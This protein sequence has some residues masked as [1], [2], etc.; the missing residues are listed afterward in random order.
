[1][2]KNGCCMNCLKAGHM[3]NKCRAP[4]SCRKCRKTHHTLL[5]I[6]S[7]EPREE[8]ASETINNVTHV[9]QLKRNKQVL[10]MTCRAKIFGPDGNFTQARVF[11]DP[12]AACSFITEELAQ[13]LRLP[14]RKSNTVIAGIAGVNAT[15]TRGAVSFTLG[16]VR[17]G[18]RKIHVE[19]AFVLSKVTTDMP[20]NLVDTLGEWK[21]LAGLELAD[22]NYG[23][24]ARV[25][26]L[27]GADYYGEVLLRGRRWGPRGTPYAQR[28]C[29]GWV[30]AGPLPTKNPRPT[31]Y[32]CCVAMEDDQLRKFWEIEDYNF[33]KPVLSLEERTVVEHF[34]VS[35]F[36]DDSGRFVVPLPRKKG[37]IAL[38]ESRAQAL[39]R[40]YR[41][42]LSLRRKGAFQ[43]FADVIREYFELGHAEPVPI[44]ELDRQ[45]TEVYYF[46]MHA[47]RKETSSTSKIRVVFDASAKSTSGA[48]LNDHLLVGPTVHSSLVDVL[49]RFRQHKVALTTDVSRMYRAVLL[50]KEQRD[51]HR[52]LWREDPHQSVKDYRMTRL[53][54]GVSASSFAA[55][56]AL[57]QNAIS[58]RQSHPQAYQAVLE[59]FYVD[60]GLTGADSVDEAV[61]LREE[62][63]EL[64]SLGGFELRKWKSSSGEVLSSIPK[65]LTDP[66]TTQ[67]II[68][69]N[70]YTK[71]LGVEWNAVTDC[72]RPMISSSWLRTPLTKRVLVSSVARVFDVLGWCS[73]AIIL[74]K[75]LLQRLWERNL[76]WDEPVPGEIEQTWK[77]WHEELPDLREHVIA[78][79]YFPKQVEIISMEL[80]GFCDASEVAYSSVVYLRA[81]DSE[82]DV[83]ISLVMAKTKVAPIKRLSIP[84]LELCSGV[85]LSKIL[86]HVADTLE[87]PSANVFAWTDSQVVLGWLLGE[88]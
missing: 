67:E 74:L 85:V 14:R 13:Q 82:G 81:I 5:H 7:S 23:T 41:M 43:E 16:H 70:D 2:K 46:P 75:I 27:L 87:I 30:L 73:P 68:L 80:H 49:I 78:R 9:P 19:D 61:Q 36:K 51:L 64:F 54:F 35:H 59:S 6:D 50:H 20:M 45:C 34:S 42:E 26:I 21:H 28:T 11:L 39:E 37:I 71:V 55:N 4:Q 47:V 57:K 38:G 62:L 32:T 79:P 48:S 15:R 3:A 12:G 53:T 86:S 44:K 17:D 58:H 76:E 18:K 84:R 25:D 66:K 1:M 40:F 52:F 83:H 88:P 24:P 72:F 10:L 29:F 60:D 65:G 56:M 33:K 77:R 69:E 8:P 22:P 63:Q 31:A